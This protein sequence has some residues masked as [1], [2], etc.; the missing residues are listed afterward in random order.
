MERDMGNEVTC[1]NR[2]LPSQSFIRFRGRLLTIGS[3]AFIVGVLVLTGLRYHTH[4]FWKYEEKRLGLQ[5][6]RAIPD[7]P[8]PKTLIPDD[9]VRCRVGC[10]EFSLPYELAASETASANGSSLFLCQHGSRVVAVSACIDEYEVAGLLKAATHLCPGSQCYTMPSLR[11]ACY[12]ASSD[13]FSWAMTPEEVRWHAF[14]ITTSQL[15]RPT[16]DGHTESLLRDDLE[17]IA[18][19]FCEGAAFE[20]QSKVHMRGGYML[21]TD[22]RETSDRDWIRAVCQSVKAV[23]EPE[24]DSSHSPTELRE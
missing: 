2:A 12:Q 21:F 16:S 10:V 11:L 7:D 9:W 17:G 23:I 24:A 6:I 4:L 8:M 15:I 22:R 14:C 1:S 19:F 18:H 20:W 13:D 5:S 3:V